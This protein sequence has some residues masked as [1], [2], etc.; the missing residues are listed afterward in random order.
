M[1]SIITEG[2]TVAGMMTVVQGGAGST[3]VHFG[4]LHS[5]DLN[6]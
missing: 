6:R 1:K 3:P 5:R 2:I 4:I